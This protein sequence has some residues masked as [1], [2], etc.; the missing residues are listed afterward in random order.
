MVA[1]LLVLNDDDCVD[2][3]VDGRVDDCVDDRV[4]AVQY[5]LEKI[6]DNKKSAPK[7]KWRRKCF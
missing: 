7:K 6:A 5:S 3:C 4:I 1:H 2:D